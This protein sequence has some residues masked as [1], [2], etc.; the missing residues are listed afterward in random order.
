MSVFEKLFRGNKRF[1]RETIESRGVYM[2]EPEIPVD[3]KFTIHFNK[4][5]GKFLYCENFQEIS[6]SLKHIQIENH[7]HNHPFYITDPQL[8]ERFSEAQLSFTANCEE[9]MVFFTSCEHL[10][11]HNGSI[12]VCSRQI[13]EKKLKELP[14]NLIV[15]ATTSQ[16]VDSISEALKVIKSRY[17]HNI[18]SNITAVKHFQPSA[19]NKNDFLSYGSASKNVYLLLLEDF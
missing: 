3:E 8:K 7:W 17:Q 14:A 5:G 1:S 15:F 6:E 13:Q 12:L 4:N 16:L 18:P 9:S 11:A 19:E 2:P 10:I